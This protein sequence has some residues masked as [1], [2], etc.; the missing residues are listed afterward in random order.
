MNFALDFLRIC[1]NILTGVSRICIDYKPL[2]QC[3][4]LKMGPING[5]EKQKKVPSRKNLGTKTPS[6]GNE[7]I[8]EALE[9]TGH[10]IQ[11]HKLQGTL[12]AK[13]YKQI[14]HIGKK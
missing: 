9:S 2:S 3:G 1:A 10:L 11:L 6:A 12:L 8:D 7:N 4:Q 14:E 5:K 13:L